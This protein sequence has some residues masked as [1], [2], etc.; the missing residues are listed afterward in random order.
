MQ[1]FVTL[2]RNVLMVCIAGV[3][4]YEYFPFPPIVWRMVFVCI[5]LGCVIARAMTHRMT[6]MEKLLLV[7][8]VL[9]FVY[10]LL[11]LSEMRVGITTAWGNILFALLSIS[12]FAYLGQQGGWSDRA[13][14]L[15]FV[16]LLIAC[17][18]YFYNMRDSL[19]LNNMLDEDAGI[20]NNAGVVFVMLMPWLFVLKKRW[21]ATIGLF[22]CLF[23]IVLSAKRGSIVAAVVPSVLFVAFYV[24]TFNAWW[25]KCL[26]LVAILLALF[27]GVW[28]FL[29][30]DEYLQQRLE[31]TQAGDSSGRDTIYR[32]ALDCWWYSDD[33]QFW[34]GH[35]FFATVPELG[36]MAHNDWLEILVDYGLVGFVLYASIVWGLWRQYR[37][38]KTLTGRMVLLSCLSIWGLR[39]LFSMVFFE[40]ALAIMSVPLGIVLGFKQQ[41]QSNNY[42]EDR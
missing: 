21:L 4:L 34:L 29:N 16:G 13:I 20:T 22:A 9:N 1:N 24:R 3:L 27:G 7:F 32:N 10:Y 26:F 14:S 17:V 12:A 40:Q 11:A 5:C 33:A 42:H 37:C 28:T 41:N 23:Y 31:E 2:V 38:E 25:K 36:K 35:G 8:V 18:V 39:S 6:G 19:L 15:W 30:E